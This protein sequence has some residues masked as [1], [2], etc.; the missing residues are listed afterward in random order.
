MK[1]PAKPKAKL[2]ISYSLLQL[3]STGRHEEAISLYLHKDL[4]KT[5]A[6]TDGIKFHKL[7]E[8]E[9]TQ[10]KNITVGNTHF[11][12]KNPRPE[13]KIITPYN[14]R[15]DMSGTIDCLDDKTVYEFKT[16]VVPS[17]DYAR[18]YQI[19]FYFLLME[20]E[21]IVVENAYVIHYNQY[22]NKTDWTMIWNGPLHI[23]KAQNFIDSL[24]PEIEQFFTEQNIPFD[25]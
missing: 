11:S 1:I 3:W 21:N 19:P 6:M 25:K 16:G 18:G 12:L 5:K 13:Y 14:E 24:A 15:W 20:K 8:E 7:M 10:T 17:T 2:R 4:P 9:I 22:S 23:Q